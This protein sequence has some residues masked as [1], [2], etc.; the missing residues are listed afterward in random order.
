MLPRILPSAPTPLRGLLD[1]WS[2]RDAWSAAVKA[3]R[4]WLLKHCVEPP[5]HFMGDFARFLR[6]VAV[7]PSEWL[8]LCAQGTKHATAYHVE[9]CRTRIWRS[10]LASTCVDLQLPV[11]ENRQCL[12]QGY[13]TCATIAEPPSKPQ[14][15]GPIIGGALMGYTGLRGFLP[16]TA[17]AGVAG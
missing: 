16:G 14:R 4:S 17:S 12:E 2:G 1:L 9:L 6:A 11:L 10:G 15:R 13:Y 3:D 8:S 5:E 7:E